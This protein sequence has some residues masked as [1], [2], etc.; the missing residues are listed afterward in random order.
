M[1]PDPLKRCH[2]CGSNLIYKV[3]TEISIKGVNVM[4]G[5]S[6]STNA[7]FALFLVS[8]AFVVLGCSS[9]QVSSVQDTQSLKPKG[10]PRNAQDLPKEF[11][12][13]LH[14][15]TTNVQLEQVDSSARKFSL[16]TQEPAPAVATYYKD[17]FAKHG[18]QTSEVRRIPGGGISFI[19]HADDD[20]CKITVTDLGHDESWAYVDMRLDADDTAFD[21]VEDGTEVGK[22]SD[23]KSDNWH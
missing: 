16:M 9:P 8:I 7:P 3:S 14:A 5:P 4:L 10:E 17:E 22:T 19:A 11:P 18:W 6:Q 12:L 20:K 13:A 23:D 15:Q 21:S 2:L 1:E